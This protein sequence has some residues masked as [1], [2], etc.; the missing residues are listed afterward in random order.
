[1]PTVLFVLYRL[2]VLSLATIW[3]TRIFKKGTAW[4][5]R[6]PND[7]TEGR[8]ISFKRTSLLITQLLISIRLPCHSTVVSAMICLSSFSLFVCIIQCAVCF[9]FLIPLRKEW[10][11]YNCGICCKLIGWVILLRLTMHGC[12]AKCIV[13]ALCV[14][15]R[16]SMHVASILVILFCILQPIA[17]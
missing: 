17:S 16:H 15:L 8:P 6:Q 9:L 1:M 10:Y 13:G 2:L 7:D 5:G 14:Q 11:Y 3:P 12:V 4:S